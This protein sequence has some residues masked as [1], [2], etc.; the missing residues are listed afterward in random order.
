MNRE[1]IKKINESLFIGEILKK[2]IRSDS[3]HAT[4][5]GTRYH[6]ILYVVNIYLM[7]IKILL[8]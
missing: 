6:I 4:S 3:S 1:Q 7:F 8:I 2:C 5:L